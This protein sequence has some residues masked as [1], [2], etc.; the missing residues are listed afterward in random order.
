MSSYR[1]QL[2]LLV[3][4][5]LLA[6]CRKDK[7]DC[8]TDAVLV[9]GRSQFVGQYKVYDT[10]GV[11][12][13]SMEILKSNDP[14]RDSL[15]VVNWGTRFDFYVR[16]E[17]GDMTDLFNFNPPFPSID[18]L[19]NHWAFTREYDSA[20]MSSRLVDDTLRMSYVI[21]NIAFYAEDGVPFFTWSYREY[22][23]KQ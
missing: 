16:H 14:G 4:S 21:N 17:D 9:D 11:Y 6:A 19:G 23:V 22:G 20:F 13:Y 1:L 7:D 8:S 12:L 10:T 3:V 5:I 18:H 15:F 2:V